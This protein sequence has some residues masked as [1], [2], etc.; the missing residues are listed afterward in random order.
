MWC[1]YLQL[2]RFASTY[3]VSTP[4]SR[5]RS[6]ERE[7]EPVRCV[8]VASFPTDFHCL[9]QIRSRRESSRSR[10]RRSRSRSRDRRPRRSYRS[11]SR[12]RDYDRRNKDRDYDRRERYSPEK[13]PVVKGR[14][15]V[16]VGRLRADDDLET[17]SRAVIR[18]A[19]IACCVCFHAHPRI[20]WT[21][22]IRRSVLF[23]CG[24]ASS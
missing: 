21:I 15:A 20:L 23:C 17:R 22:V 6:R 19:T 8:A 13:K 1:V 2:A 12:S 16:A 3:F 14:G 18:L 9:C 10:N 5:S 11:R 7:R 4:Q 24:L